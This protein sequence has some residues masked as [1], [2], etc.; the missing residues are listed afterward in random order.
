MILDWRRRPEIT[1]FMF[2]DVADDL[3]RQKAWLKACAGRE[4]FR[5]FVIGHEGRPIGYLSYSEIDRHHRRC[6]SGSYVAEESDR[7]RLAGF[8][9]PFILDYCFYRLGMEKLV[10]SFMEGNDGVIRIQCR[11]GFREVGVLRRHIRKYD[12]WHDVFLF[13]LLREE[14]E[15]RPRPFP[16]EQTLAAFED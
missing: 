9:Y 16:R 6:G 3:E 2:T 7:R 4:D 5:H 14:W 8:L 12:R 10:N 1:R 11:L 15:T 13:E